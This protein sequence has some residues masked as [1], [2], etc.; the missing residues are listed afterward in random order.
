MAHQ[1]IQKI[2]MIDTEHLTLLLIYEMLIFMRDAKG[3]MPEKKFLEDLKPKD[4]SKL[5]ENKL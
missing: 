4:F 3:M 1:I 2:I 5:L